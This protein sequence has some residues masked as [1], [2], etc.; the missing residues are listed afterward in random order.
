M[1]KLRIL[2]LAASLIAIPLAAHAERLVLRNSEIIELANSVAEIVDGYSEKL[3]EQPGRPA[4]VVKLN[5]EFSGEVR[6]TLIKN[7]TTLKVKLDEFNEAKK[8]FIREIAGMDANGIPAEDK[9]G[10]AAFTKKWEELMLKE[11]SLE[12]TRIYSVDLKLDKNPIG[13]AATRASFLIVDLPQSLT[14]K[15]AEVAA[16]PKK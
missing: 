1:N 2:I 14:G 3:I 5:F 8:G 10:T 13:S 4:Q 16:I 6:L 11:T 7:L 15:P 12:L 9:K